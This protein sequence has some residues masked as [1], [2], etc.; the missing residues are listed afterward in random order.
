MDDHYRL[1]RVYKKTGR[2]VLGNC[3]SMRNFFAKIKKNI[4]S[5]EAAIGRNKNQNPILVYQ[6]G[7]VGSRSIYESLKE[8]GYNVYHVHHLCH[9]DEREQSVREKYSNPQ[10]SLKE[11]EKG[12]AIRSMID[13][14][15][16]DTV[17]NVI[18][19]VRDPIARHVSA[20][21]ELLPQVFRDFDRNVLGEQTTIEKIQ[22]LV[23][24][25][26]DGMMSWHE[27]QL[28]PVFDIDVY[29]VP[30]P[31]HQGYQ[32]YKNKKTSLL[33]VRLENLNIV[34]NDAFRDFLGVP[35][36]QLKR[37]NSA[38][39]KK[40]GNSYAKFRDLRFP[41][42]YINQ[43]YCNKFS[44]HFYDTTELDVFKKKWLMK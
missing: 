17:W 3:S 12:R 15:S 22:Q 24:S 43:F 7:K 9:L 1:Y 41:I 19:M 6:P 28:K 14:L 27:E 37:K 32:I 25:L 35:N 33:L 8:M 44:R 2:I 36:V 40:Y 39:D 42:E 5:K 38:E 30:F 10:F 4:L 23:M 31:H 34:A 18:T 13:D 16:N 26:P 20:V 11:I 29:G 21:F